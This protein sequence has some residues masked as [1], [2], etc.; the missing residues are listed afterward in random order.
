MRR[1]SSR[2]RLAFGVSL[3]AGLLVAVAVGAVAA[4]R[5]ADTS[6][7]VTPADRGIAPTK[8][9]SVFDRP[10]PAGDAL[11]AA[12]RKAL[13][14]LTQDEPGV[15]SSL[16]PGKADLVEGRNL[17]SSP[18][19]T[20]A[21]APTG[22]GRVCSVVLDGSGTYTAGGCIDAFTGKLPIVPNIT[23]LGSGTTVVSGLASDSVE[24]VAVGVD[25]V[26]HQA[27]LQN[28][29]FLFQTSSGASVSSV[30]ATLADGSRVTVPLMAPNLGG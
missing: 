16:L 12:G 13:A 28:D 21:A 14:S 23:T 8:A 3:A 1:G 15:D 22:K 19:W 30:V 29:A 26:E 18:Q 11:S 24:A 5:D 25:G 7:R 6:N 2:N 9:M 17:I 27:T 4:T 10:S 20:L